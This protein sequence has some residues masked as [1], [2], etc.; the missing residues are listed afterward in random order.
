MLIMDR[1]FGIDLGTTNSVIAYTDPTATTEVIAGQDGNR[2]VPSVIYFPKNG[3]PIVGT[4]ARQRAITEPDRVAMLFKRGMGEGTFLPDEQPF[5]VDGKTWSPEELSA[6][7]LRKLALMAQ[8]RYSEPVR[9]VV[10]TVPAYFGDNERDA[11]KAA[12]E[13]AGLQV[14]HIVNEPTAAAVAHGLDHPEQA[15]RVLVFDLGGGTFDVTVMDVSADGSMKVLATGGDRKLGGMD[16]DELILGKMNAAAR[17]GGLDIETEAWARQDAYGKAEAMKKELSSLDAA[18]TSL[19]GSGRPLQFDLTRAEF[20]KLL[21]DKL[22]SVEDTTLYT[23]EEAGLQPSDLHTVLMVGGSSRIPAFQEL[24]EKVIGR[25]PAFSRNLDEDVARGAAILAAKE[26]GDL[27][28]RSRLA[29]MPPPVDVASHGLGVEVM[30][31]ETRQMYNSIIIQAQTPVPAH[32]EETFNTVVEGQTQVDI[33]LNEGDDDDLQFVKQI[34]TGTGRFAAAVPKDHPV[35]ISIDFARDGTIVLNAHDGRDGTFLC[36]LEVNRPG[37][38][39]QAARLNARQ[40]LA[41]ME[42][43]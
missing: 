18:S 32:G 38:L 7:V 16:F 42:V 21:K 29:K 11:T 31:E 26:G 41:R 5:V 1:I 40:V 35:K 23:V 3:D 4:N 8:E 33:S 9:K 13:I 36:Q 24:L 2:I 17:A 27:D 6:L 34:A 25:P 12:G 14:L 19:T 39:G 10:I 20:E 43:K 15:G 22:T 30:N 28:P 37:N